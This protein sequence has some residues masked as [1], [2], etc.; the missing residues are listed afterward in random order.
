MQSYFEITA[1]HSRKE[2]RAAVS[3]TMGDF[4]KDHQYSELSGTSAPE[5]EHHEV[6]HESSVTTTRRLRDREMLKRKKEETQAKDTYQE[7]AISKRQ[8]KTKGTGRGRRKE[9]KEPEPEPQPEPEPEQ[10]PVH[11]LQ[12]DPS[13]EEHHYE[14]EAE[15]KFELFSDA[16]HEHIEHGQE[17]E[18]LV[19]HEDSVP[20]APEGDTADVTLLIH[21]DIDGH[22]PHETSSLLKDQEEAAVSDSAPATEA[23]EVLAFTFEQEQVE[24]QYYTPLL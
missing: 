11:E 7:Q 4:E 17:Q 24:H 13:Q 10:E 5:I 18:L 14:T 2:T 22:L 20:T 21:E 9:V 3:I 6:K 15:N 1:N 16:P 12:H 23:P 19:H 8:R